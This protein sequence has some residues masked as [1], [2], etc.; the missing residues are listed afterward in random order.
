MNP[1][2]LARLIGDHRRLSA[3]LDANE[4]EQ[5]RVELLTHIAIEEKLLMPLLGASSVEKLLL[6]ALRADHSALASLTIP[7]PR[8]ELLANIRAIL[9]AHEPLEESAEGLYPRCVRIA[10]D[11]PELAL[12]IEQIG[13][14][15]VS[16]F[17]N[18]PLIER[19]IRRTLAAA[20][21]ARAAYA[22]G[23]LR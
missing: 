20:E 4:F 18:G 16:P 11:D 3:L 21:Q 15:S 22:R 1:P 8:P 13:P 17:R 9:R 2:W 23:Q 5:F 10:G 14:R 12:K 6:R 19:Q 7:V